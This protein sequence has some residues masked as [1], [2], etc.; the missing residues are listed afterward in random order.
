MQAELLVLRLVHILGGILWVGSG[1]YSFFFL[2]PAISQAGPAGGQVMA[3]LQ[4]RRLFTVLPIIAVLTILSGIRLMMIVS[5]GSLGTYVGTTVGRTYAISGVLAIAAF[6]LSVVISRPGAVRLAKLSQ[7][8]V[9]DKNSRD[10]I[11]SEIKALQTRVAMSGQIAVGLLVLS[12][13]GMAIAR[14]L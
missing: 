12:A 4:K 7:S 5:G 1:M 2:I 14:Y 13:A 10:L 3:N 6:I 9:S 8:A 11:Q